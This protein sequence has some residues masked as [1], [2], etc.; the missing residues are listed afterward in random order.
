MLAKIYLPVLFPLTVV[1]ALLALK[2]DELLGMKG[3]FLPSPLNLWLAAFSFALGS[4]IWIV[5]YAAIVFEGKGSPSPTAGRTQQLVTGGIYALCRYPSVHG[6]FWG[7]LAVGL[8]LNSIS[9]CVILA[10][11]LLVGSLVE[12][13]WRQEPKNEDIFGEAWREYRA[14]VPFFVPWKILL[15][16]SRPPA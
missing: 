8:A 2:I 11:L 5:A 9:F 4:V 15:P 16:R 10:P 14:R 3:G 7:V 12:K 13:W 6:K 1:I